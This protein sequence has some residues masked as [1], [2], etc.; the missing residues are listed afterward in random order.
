MQLK[1]N[2]IALEETRKA[3]KQNEQAL[4]QNAVALSINNKE[5]ANSTHQLG[6][7]T[8]A[9]QEIEKTQKLQQFENNFY[10]LFSQ[11]NKLQDDVLVTQEKQIEEI[12]ENTST[13]ANTQN[14]IVNNRIISRY[15]ILLYQV[16]KM[17]EEKK[18]TFTNKKQGGN[19]QKFYTN[20]IP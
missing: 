12:L 14:K 1:H 19:T 3:I 8:Q 18:E 7:A 6:L 20:L 10:E 17:I 2:E 16:L 13:L 11:L 15:F 9:H 5:L 4:A